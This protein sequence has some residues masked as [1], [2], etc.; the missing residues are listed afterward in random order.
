[1]TGSVLLDLESG[2]DFKLKNTFKLDRI[3]HPLTLS[4]VAW[5]AHTCYWN[6]EDTALFIMSQLCT[7]DSE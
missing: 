3:D 1:M 2:F 7:N 5:Q 4:I 6:S